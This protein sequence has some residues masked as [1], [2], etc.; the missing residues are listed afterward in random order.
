MRKTDPLFFS[1]LRNY[2]SGA[3]RPDIIAGLVTAA[4]VIPKAM[5]YASIAGLPVE[6]GLYTVFIPMVIYAVLGSS[7]PLSVST[8]TTIA[9]LTGAAL[10]QLD[11]AVDSTQLLIA[12]ITLAFL[13]GVMLVI[14]SFFKLGFVANFISEP[15]LVGFK[16]GIGIVIVLD[17]IPKLLGIHFDKGS[18]L[19]NVL[20]IAQH[21]PDTSI[22]TLLMGIATIVVLVA[23]HHFAPRSPAPLIAVAVGIIASSVLGLTH[24]GVETIGNIPQSL[25]AV[26]LPMLSLLEQ[27]WPAALGIALMSFVES[28]ASGRAFAASHEPVPN[29]NREL[30]ATG[31]SNIGG[32]FLSAMPAGGGTSQTA[33]NRMAGAQTQFAAIVTASMAV[34][35][36]LLFAPILGFMPQATLA[37]IV[38]IYSIELIQPNEFRAIFQIRRME[39]IWAI[40]ACAG[41][42][43]LGTLEGIV[44]AIVISM[45]DLAQQSTNPPVYA[46]ARNRA[47]QLFEPLLKTKDEL[48]T[49]P[50]LLMVRVEGRIY[51]ANAQTIEEKIELLVDEFNP[52]VVAFDLSRVFDMEYSTI[53]MLIE[54]EEK[55]RKRGVML[56]L[57]APNP[58]V[59]Q[60][61]ERS[62]LIETLGKNR[63]HLNANIAMNHYL[64][65]H[66]T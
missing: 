25:P 26:T 64:E 15:V 47:T 8:T 20:G 61:L 51:F 11:P 3:L 7:R 18:F 30:L 29:A 39:F 10:G 33:V 24:Q 59:K 42:I 45:L 22:N 57:V 43:V 50:G 31:L 9:I 23:L 41:V 1:W 2:P 36:M 54:D 35:T 65:Q 32:A 56:W 14:A 46:I 53:K 60:L 4:V 44:V 6:V 19:Q 63:V 28:I 17:Q 52:Q 37:A 49:A 12:A 66:E 48:E 40:I 5:A 27:L 62:P 38:I 58:G 55:Y 16:S 21:I 13:V 34:T